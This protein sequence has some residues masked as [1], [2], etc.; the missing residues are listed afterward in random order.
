MKF[1][2]LLPLFILV[3]LT[4]HAQQPI[5]ITRTDMPNINDTFRYSTVDNLL[6]LIDLNDTGAD[7]VWDYS[8]LGS[9]DQRVDEWVDPITGTPLIYNITF[10]NFFD[11]DHFST[12]SAP[13]VFGQFNQSFVAIE[14]VYDFYK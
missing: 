11:M 4:V 9:F 10:S 3:G 2:F 6:G 5:S 8:T 1:S 14:D 13:N 12:I 7:M